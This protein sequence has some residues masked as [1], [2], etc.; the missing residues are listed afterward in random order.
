MAPYAGFPTD[1]EN[2]AM[3]LRKSRADMDAEARGEGETLSKHRR[4]LMELAKRQRYGIVDIYEEIVSGERILD[5]PEMQRLL[6]AVQSGK[7][8]AV[9]CMDIDRLGRGNMI[10]QGLIQDAFKSSGTLIITPRKVYNLED[11]MDEEWSEFEAFM[12]RREL[13]IITR[14]MQRGRRDSSRDGKHVAKKPP[15]GYMRGEDLK[16]YPDPETAPIVRQIFEWSA[17]GLGQQI[18]A[19]KLTELGIPSPSGRPFW[20]PSSV[21]SILKNPVYRGHI[22][23]GRVRYSK[24]TDGNRGYDRNPQPKDNWIVNEN[25]HEPL[26]DEETYARYQEAVSRKPKVSDKRTLTNP[27]A[28]IVICSQCQHVMHRRPRYNRPH[29]QLLCVTP[30][31]NTR[32]ISFDS[33]EVR[34]LNTLRQMLADFKFTYKQGRKRKNDGELVLCRR[35]AN[36]LQKSMEELRVQRNNLH[37]L[38]ERGIYDADTFLERNRVITERLEATERELSNVKER[39]ADLE[40]RANQ[41]TDIH[42]RLVSVLKNYERALTAKEKNDLLK[43]VIERVEYTRK[44][45]WTKRDQ[46]ELTIHL[47]L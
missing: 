25:A 33:V 7:Y 21:F 39:I 20:Q 18:I 43:S 2:M 17:D 38:L 34:I 4:T 40:K 9:L 16:L 12:A 24:R 27:L 6:S 37:D 26:V 36:E 10:D 41:A 11:E 30:G 32:G 35:K 15:Y 13:K 1:L 47:R 8:S 46:F 23:W 44:Q 42:P 5:R 28:S 29:D 19:R 14:R 3:Y 22:V 31:C 45:E